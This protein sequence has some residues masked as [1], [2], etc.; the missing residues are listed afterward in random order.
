MKITDLIVSAK[1]VATENVSL[2][3]SVAASNAEH[4]SRMRKSVRTVR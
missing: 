2:D 3:M 4:L 1:S